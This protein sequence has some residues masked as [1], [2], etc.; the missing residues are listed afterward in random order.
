MDKN[1]VRL[2]LVWVSGLCFG[3]LVGMSI[4]EKINQKYVVPNVKRYKELSE[5]FKELLC[6]EYEK[7][8]LLK[9]EFLKMKR[10]EALNDEEN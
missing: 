1:N 4:N 6:K 5:N 2:G 10:E 8:D 7:N 9:K 3:A